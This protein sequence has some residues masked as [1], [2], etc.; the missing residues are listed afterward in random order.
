M[1]HNDFW[2]IHESYL[3][4]GSARMS[5][6]AASG[7]SKPRSIPFVPIANLKMH[8]GL[9]MTH[10]CSWF[11]TYDVILNESFLLQAW[12]QDLLIKSR[13]SEFFGAETIKI[14]KKLGTDGAS[15]DFRGILA[16]SIIGDS[17]FVSLQELTHQE[18]LIWRHTGENKFLK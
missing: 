10:Y 15:F 4:L 17:S 3:R 13:F 6:F 7:T 12:S 14:V 11:I 9:I 8:R 2:E 5:L 1:S 18:W 16:L